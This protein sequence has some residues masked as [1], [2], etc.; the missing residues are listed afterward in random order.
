MAA[1]YRELTVWQKSMQLAKLIYAATEQF[2]KTQQFIL[3]AQMQRAAIS[4]PSN[5]AEGYNRK[6][7]KEYIHFLSIAYGSAGELETQIT[8]AYELGFISDVHYKELCA[9]VIEISKMLH[10]MQ[11]KMK[12]AA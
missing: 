2:P 12:E 11:F 6:N 7:R 10:V 1:S 4:I 8:L 5:I 3:A 9:V